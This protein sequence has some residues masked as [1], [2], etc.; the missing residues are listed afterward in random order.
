MINNSKQ[1][2]KC[3]YAG[4]LPYCNIWVCM[5]LFIWFQ[6]FYPDE[7]N[8]FLTCQ[9]LKKSCFFLKVEGEK[10]SYP[11]QMKK[12]HIQTLL[13]VRAWKCLSTRFG[14]WHI[15]YWLTNWQKCKIHMPKAAVSWKFGLCSIL[16]HYLDAPC[17]N[18]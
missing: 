13:N 9:F 1:K 6:F 15:Q 4:H 8:V 5:F 12:R 7:K 16:R 10:T 2:F 18:F 11:R 17:G 14:N 3:F